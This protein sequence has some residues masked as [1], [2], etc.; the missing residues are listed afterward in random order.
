MEK[1]GLGFRDYENY[2]VKVQISA[3][4]TGADRNLYCCRIG[5]NKYLKLSSGV[6]PKS[7]APEITA[8]RIGV[9][10]DTTATEESIALNPSSKNWW[11]K[12]IVS[13]SPASVHSINSFASA[14]S[15]L[16]PP[17]VITASPFV[18]CTRIGAS[19]SSTNETRF[20]DST[21]AL[22]LICATVVDSVGSKVWY[23]GK[24]AA[25][26]RLV[27]CRPDPSI[28]IKPSLP[29]ANASEIDSLCESD[30]E[31][32]D[33]NLAGTSA[34]VLSDVDVG[35]QFNSRTAKR[36]LSV[37]ASVITAPS[38]SIFTPVNAGSV[39][40]RDAAMATWEIAVAKSVPATV[41]LTPG[42]VGSG[43]YSAT[44]MVGIVKEERP[45]EIFARF[46]SIEKS[47]T[48]EGS[49]RVISAKRRPG[50][51]TVPV[52]ITSAF[53]FALALTSASLPES[54]KPDF[55]ATKCMP[56]NSG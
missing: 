5:I 50:I 46:P 44:G 18:K 53:R 55:S 45:Q 47:I 6:A 51:K 29:V 22:V 28:P 17:P 12:A 42:I 25:N 15:P 11:L 49:E 39:S 3:L 33:K 43:G 14:S 8:G 19:L 24:S 35:D 31:D 16:P 27:V 7:A 9:V 34:C 30:L 13:S 41:P 1:S 26:N 56:V 21:S 32:S 2:E 10:I 38:T 52:S 40:S 54:V 23:L 48:A 4:L 20:T 37:A 36:Y